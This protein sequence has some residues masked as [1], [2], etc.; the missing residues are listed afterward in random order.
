MKGRRTKKERLADDAEYQEFPKPKLDPSNPLI[1]VAQTI[2]E[3]W[4][5]KDGATVKDYA[6]A[7]REAT[8]WSLSLAAA[9]MESD[10]KNINWENVR[11]AMYNLF[12]VSARANYKAMALLDSEYVVPS[13]EDQAAQLKVYVDTQFYMIQAE[14]RRQKL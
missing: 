10:E 7:I 4:V 1:D 13:D 9:V 14:K 6:K 11:T 12:G 8:S 3:N 5:D 2:A